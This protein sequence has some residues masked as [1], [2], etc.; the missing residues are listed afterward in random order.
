MSIKSINYLAI[1][2]QF[3]EWFLFM[4]DNSP[5]FASCY[6]WH[7]STL[8]VE[9]GINC[10][11]Y[12]MKLIIDALQYDGWVIDVQYPPIYAIVQ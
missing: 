1:D 8:G 7:K 3:E 6:D 12:T 4:K 5:L 9:L 2:G 10:K 11:T